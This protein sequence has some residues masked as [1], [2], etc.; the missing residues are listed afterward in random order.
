LRWSDRHNLALGAY[1]LAAGLAL[2]ELFVLWQAL[3]PNV[4]DAYRAYYIDRT[5]TCLPQRVTGA[6]ALGTPLDFRSGGD[7][8]RELR[9]CGWDGPAGDGV[10]SIGESS[11]LEF[12]VGQAR[13]LVLTLELA[14]VTLPGPPQ[15]RVL[16]SANGMALG[17]LLVTPDQPERFTIDIPAEAIDTQGRLALVLDYPDAISPGPRTAN[18]HWRAIKLSAATLSPL[19]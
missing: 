12:Q 13:P 19:S 9:P 15:Q 16:L 7:E 2:L 6:Y 17:E 8:T 3:H 14:A 10:H 5:T 18:T 11:R 4:P 1:A